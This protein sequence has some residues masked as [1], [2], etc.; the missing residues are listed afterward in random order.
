MSSQNKPSSQDP[1]SST[2]PTETDLVPK[3]MDSTA[4]SPDD[5][6]M[7]H[8]VSSTGHSQPRALV[9]TQKASSP[10]LTP[11]TP[12][13][14]S[15]STESPYRSASNQSAKLTTTTTGQKRPLPSARLKGSIHKP[16]RSP[17]RTTQ[18][19]DAKPT[20]V[21][22]K[23]NP[24][25]VLRTQGTTT[26][27]P[28]LALTP[29]STP[30]TRPA[31][32]KPS[33]TNTP[34]VSKRA[35]FRPPL[36][37]SQQGPPS[38]DTAY[39]RLIQIQTLQVRVKELQSSIRKGRQILKQQQKNE[40][41]IEELTAKWKK[42]SQE[43]AQVLLKYVEQQ[44][45]FGGWSDNDD[46]GSDGRT[47]MTG[48]FYGYGS[49]QLPW[50]FTPDLLMTGVSSLQELGPEGLQAMEEYI[51]HQ[52]VQQDLPTVDEAIRS[53]SRPEVTAMLHPLTKM[54]SMQKLLLGLGIDLDVIGYDP[55]QDAFVS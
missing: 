33:T 29:K 12:P 36:S 38:N 16:F 50:S 47:S 46:N 22:M 20:A 6:S 55:E 52:D 32:A 3:T 9:E 49:H 41:P 14:C 15:T 54:T 11:E 13:N 26:V 51:E 48:G 19:I 27:T 37:R 2:S 5:S 39:G 7:S 8:Q 43:G 18:P 53:R 28:T 34:S 21:A 25:Q 4:T 24:E 35:P 10:D 17:L 42:A 1:R 23:K 40:T 45:P 30:H 44:S 31:P